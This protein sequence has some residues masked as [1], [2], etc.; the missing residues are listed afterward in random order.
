[1]LYLSLSDGSHEIPDNA[2]VTVNEP[3]ND[4]NYL[5]FESN[6]FEITRIGSNAFSEIP[7][8]LL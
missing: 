8:F 4:L 1:V 2:F 7:N 5:V 3:Q 6:N